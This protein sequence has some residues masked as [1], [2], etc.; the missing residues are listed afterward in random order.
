[1]LGALFVTVNF[2]TPSL[3]AVP[4]YVKP[5]AYCVPLLWVPSLVV[6][7]RIGCDAFVLF[8]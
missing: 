5:V 4:V 8:V 3:P 2:A 7:K 6:E 1:M